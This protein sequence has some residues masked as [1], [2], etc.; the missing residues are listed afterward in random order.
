M[1]W[2]LVVWVGL[3]AGCASAGG[4]EAG[5]RQDRNVLPREVIEQQAHYS[6]AYEMIQSLRPQW[7]RTRGPTSLTNESEIGIYMDG[8]RL[9]GPAT[10]TQVS[11]HQIELLRYYPPQEAQ[12]RWGL[13]H[14]H[15]AIE[16]ISRRR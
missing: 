14:V 8:M 1:R 16:I 7:L 10:L 4:G 9:G 13:G 2:L 15:G 11:P 6:N 3:L 12:T 5:P